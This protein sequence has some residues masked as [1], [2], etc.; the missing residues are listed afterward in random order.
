MLFR[1]IVGSLLLILLVWSC[2]TE[3]TGPYAEE[4]QIGFIFDWPTLTSPNKIQLQDYSCY[5]KVDFLYSYEKRYFDN[6]EVTFPSAEKLVGVCKNYLMW[7]DYNASEERD[8][9]VRTEIFN[10]PLDNYRKL[11]ILS[12]DTS[13]V[14][15]R[16][17]AVNEWTSG[18][19][20]DLIK[21]YE[22]QDLP[23]VEF[24]YPEVDTVK[25]QFCFSRAY[26]V[27]RHM[28]VGNVSDYGLHGTYNLP[29]NSLEKIVTELPCYKI[30]D[31]TLIDNKWVLKK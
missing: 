22:K 12:Y 18:N 11:Y 21:D 6:F 24:I 5:I 17:V 23:K 16:L 25:I 19:V 15:P 3:M 10:Y 9:K 4:P 31:F 20:W 27:G 26:Q 29:Y 13:S 8:V 2:K 28:A 1:T 30:D 7:V 14:E